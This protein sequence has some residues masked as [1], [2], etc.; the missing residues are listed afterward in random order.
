MTESNAGIP[1]KPQGRELQPSSRNA[2]APESP[3]NHCMVGA[4]GLEPR[5]SSVSKRFGHRV[6]DS[7][8]AVSILQNSIPD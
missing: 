2:S 1:N 7:L 5:T 3:A 8:E 4:R 6:F